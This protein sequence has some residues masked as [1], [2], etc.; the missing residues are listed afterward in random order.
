M[1]C[2]PGRLL[3]CAAAVT[4]L[5]AGLL[6]L[7]V[8]ADDSICASCHADAASL[9]DAGERAAKLVVVEDSLKGSAHEGLSCTDC[10]ADLAGDPPIPHPP[11]L[12]PA[13][14][15]TCHGDVVETVKSSIHTQKITPGPGYK[16]GCAACHGS[17]QIRPHGDAAS[18]TNAHNLGTTCGQ[19]HQ[20]DAYGRDPVAEWQTSVHG[21]AAVEGEEVEAPTCNVCHHPHAVRALE[22]PAEPLNRRNQPNLCGRCHTSELNALL[23]GV[24]GRAWKAGNLASAICTDCHG[25]HAIQRPQYGGSVFAAEVSETCGRCHG[26]PDLTSRYD[27]RPDSVITYD[28]SYHG[29]GAGWGAANV[30]NCASCHRFHDIRSQHDPASSVNPQNLQR[31]CGQPNCHPGATAGFSGTPVHARAIVKGIDWTRWTRWIYL[32]IISATLVFMAVHQVLE[33][34]TLLRSAHA[35]PH[36]AATGARPARRKI[37]PLSRFESRDG[38]WV[39][40]RWDRNQI[41]Q[42]LFLVISFSTLV[43]SGF[44]LYLPAAWADKLGAIGRP[45]FDLRGQVHRVAALVMIGGSLY[46]MYWL[47]FTKRGRREFVELLPDVLHDG[48]DLVGNFAWFLGFRD[49][50]PP[51]RRYTYREKLE[52]WALVWG[53]IVM[54][55]S[56]VVLWTASNWPALV[57]ELSQLVHGYEALLAFAAILLWH[58][59]GVHLKPGIFPMNRTWIDGGMPIHAMK[60]EHRDEYDEVIAW[61]GIDPE[62]DREDA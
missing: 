49:A 55:V 33:Q 30:A 37:E 48:K 7:P 9:S 10:H 13:S 28:R 53:T 8:R 25:A 34:K 32:A 29:R 17:H 44:A 50:P 26:D 2:L 11:D 56:G 20:K 12:A 6:S 3:A 27:L 46:H 41:V 51:G 36:A 24:H 54:V 4:I 1:R 15:D 45:L 14:C 18:K 35:H 60:E 5:L 39:A 19:C 57:V 62:R 38:R 31:T 59:F 23:R 43:L 61:Q 21:R 16:S 22:D 47:A 58:M 40:V 42:H 52:Y